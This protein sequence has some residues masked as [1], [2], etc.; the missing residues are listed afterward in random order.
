MST[1]RYDGLVPDDRLYC[2]ATD[3][4]VL[5][6]SEGRVR[7]GA[8][9]YGLWRCGELIA[10]TAKP[11]GARV[12]RLR[13]LATVESTKTVLAVHAPIAVHDVVGNDHAEGRPRLINDDPY[14]TGWMV[15]GMATQW[16]DDHHH[17]IDAAHYRRQRPP[18]SSPLSSPPSPP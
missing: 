3:M 8:T 17:L 6:L 4:W 2:P 18:L 7:I 1:T 10:F 11:R 14:G 15:E 9:S 12:E 5:P 16:D 13:G